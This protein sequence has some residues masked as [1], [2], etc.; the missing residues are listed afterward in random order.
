MFCGEGTGV[1][2]TQ[3]NWISQLIWD[4]SH[5]RRYER[6]AEWPDTT[7]GGGDRQIQFSGPSW[8]QNKR[9]EG[10]KK[11]CVGYIYI[12]LYIYKYIYIYIYIK[13]IFIYIYILLD[14]YIYL[15]IYIY[16]FMID[17]FL[18]GSWVQ[19]ASGSGSICNIRVQWYWVRG[20]KR[21]EKKTVD[22]DME[23]KKKGGEKNVPRR[24]LLT[25]GEEQKAV[26]LKRRCDQCFRTLEAI[27][28]SIRAESL[29]TCPRFTPPPH[30]PPPWSERR[31]HPHLSRFPFLT[32]VLKCQSHMKERKFFSVPRDPLARNT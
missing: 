16:I 25:A 9:S 31:L 28:P 22:D 29:R 2:S 14:I 24:K 26:M 8:V 27:T 30:P 19:L 11:G 4:A 7:G 3:T 32:H 6:D 15:Y 18:M 10:R 5:A 21:R 13:Y 12:L 17:R 1:I 23:K 20:K